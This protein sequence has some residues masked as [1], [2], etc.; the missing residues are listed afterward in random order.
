MVQPYLMEGGGRNEDW[1][2]TRREESR[3][4]V[5]ENMVLRKIFGPSRKKQETGENFVKKAYDF[6]RSPNIIRLI[7]PK[8]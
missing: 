3:L 5:F 2:L 1:S 6:Y 8:R 4:N 7:K